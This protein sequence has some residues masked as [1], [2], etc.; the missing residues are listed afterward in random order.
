MSRRRATAGGQPR[1]WRGESGFSRVPAGVLIVALLAVPA[2]AQQ[3]S[4]RG[5]L[6]AR[7]SVYPL[8]TPYDSTNVVGS[9]LFRDEG[10]WRPTGWLTLAGGFEAQIDTH[11]RVEREWRLD[12]DD[13]GMLRPALSVRRLSAAVR[14]A[15]VTLEAGKQFVRWGKAD[16][17]NPT[18]RFAPRDFMEV[19]NND[20]LG[21][22]AARLTWERRSDTVEA[23]WARFTPSRVPLLTDRWAA[24]PESLATAGPGGAS[25]V[26]VDLG[27]DYPARA[28]LGVRW[29][30]V[31][32]GFE[33]SLSAYDGF[34]HLPSF[35]A[36]VALVGSAVAPGSSPAIPAVQF[37]RSYPRMRMLGGDAAVPLRWFT[38]K[39]EAAFFTSPDG[40]ADEYGICVLQLERQ[41]GEWFFVGGYAG[42]VVGKLRAA[43]PPGSADT[44]FALDRGLADAFLGRAS[45]T[46]DVNRSLAFEGALRWNADGVWLKAEY[47][48]AAG[49]HL[50]ATIR[51]SLIRGDES[52]FLGRYRL[53]SGVEGVLRYSF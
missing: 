50:R 32:S 26:I 52:D 7:G 4:Q 12:W 2:G 47:S 40:Q 20:F 24:L 18:D 31:A 25:P 8:D 49:Q 11:G 9:F 16:I 13:R 10:F 51:G 33:L 44:A 53:N 35:E 28:Q 15:G 34:N 39:G 6:D 17:L 27:A 37:S 36:R 38:L 46:I 21:V 43:A 23:V 1:R 19:V 48:Q 14:R 42:E 5:F 3:L 22:T 41:A 45:Y 29:N 30:H